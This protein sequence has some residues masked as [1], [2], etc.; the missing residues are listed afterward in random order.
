MSFLTACDFI[1]N[2]ISSR[3]YDVVI[4][5]VDAEPDV[6]TSGLSREIKKSEKQNG[7]RSHIYGAE[8]TDT[9]TFNFS[10]VKISGEEI[11][12]I[13]SIRINK[14]LTSSSLPQLLKF[15]DNDAYPLHYYAV[16]T[17][18]KDILAGGRLI[19]KDLIFETDSAYAFSDKMEKTF[20]IAG[21]K[22]FSL[23]NSS[24]AYGGI[25]YPVVTIEDQS[26]DSIIIENMTDK[27]SVTINTF[28]IAADGDGKRVVKLDSEKMTALD[29]D[30]RLLP[31]NKLGWGAGYRSYVFSIG[32]YIDGI[33]WLRLLKG[34]N[35]IKVI[36]TCILKIT[37][38]YPR[39]AGCL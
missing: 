6:A 14:W 9:I 10:I 17:Q 25:Y 18:I 7:T 5:W 1:F 4:S 39:K 37:Y 16:C 11:T 29:K 32:D 36:G 15:N 22:T 19:G 26:T 8:N 38:E 20:E 34:V 30:G 27:K 3:D 31:I 33:Y 12:R 23:N 28:A 13:E 21:S 2:G 35:E 24:D